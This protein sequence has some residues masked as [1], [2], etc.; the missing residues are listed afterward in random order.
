MD[1]DARHFVDTYYPIVM[2]NDM[3]SEAVLFRK[4]YGPALRQ[5]YVDKKPEGY[6]DV[7]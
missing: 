2:A 3:L 4:K 6:F 7:W 5:L 1:D